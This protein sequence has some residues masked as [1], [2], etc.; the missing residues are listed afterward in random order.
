MTDA[1]VR[2]MLRLTKAQDALLREPELRQALKGA[3][4]LAAIQ[5]QIDQDER[6]R[7]PGDVQAEQL[8]PMEALELYLK[9]REMPSDRRQ[10]MLA[11]A[12]TLLEQDDAAPA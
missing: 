11:A 6:R 9:Q 2:V 4:V 3:H 12:R 5:R 1:I 8:E 7:L 10:R